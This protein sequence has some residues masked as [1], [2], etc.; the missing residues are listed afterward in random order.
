VDGLFNVNSTSIEAWKAM[1]GSLKGRQI[2]VRDETGAESVVTEEG[3]PVA[4]LRGP[5]SA[6]VD[7]DGNLDVKDPAQWIGR[8]SLSEEDIE[9]LATAIV[10]EVRKRGPFLSLA[11]FVNRRPGNDEDLARAGAIQSALDARDVQIN[12]GFRG[13]GRSVGGDVANRF[14]FPEAEEGTAGY[15]APG[16]VKQGDILTPIA[17]VLSARSDSFIIRA[18]GESVD[19]E[20]KVLARAWCEATVERDKHF[21]DTHDAPETPIANLSED[22]NETFGRRYVMASF[23]WLHPEEI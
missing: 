14:A 22:V 23:R 6:L 15:G 19:A 18:Y 17:P 16:V 5:H 21:I 7:G 12:E 4:N 10:R 13:S 3:T 2:V 8:R 1:L 11:D 9:S 20:G